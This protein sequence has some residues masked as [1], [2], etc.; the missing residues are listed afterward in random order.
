MRVFYSLLLI[1]WGL[2]PSEAQAKP[3]DYLQQCWSQQGQPLATGY[4]TFRYQETA[5]ELEHSQYPWQPTRY[6][7]HGTAWLNAGNFL[8]QDTLTQDGK[9][10]SSKSQL[11]PEELLL[12]DYGDK[13]LL[14]VTPA[15]FAGYVLTTARYS[16]VLLLQYFVQHPAAVTRSAEPGLAVYSAPVADARVRLFIRQADGLL[17][18]A[19][20]L[21]PDELF[22]DVLTTY[23]YQSYARTGKV[24]YPTT[25]GISKL[26]GRIRDDVR[27]SAAGI[28][29]GASPVLSRPEGY[30]MRAVSPSIPPIAVQTY[31][32][33]LHFLELKHTDDRVLVVEFNDFLV[34]AEAPLTSENGEAI[35]AET[36]RLAPGKPV[37]YFV[38]GHYHPH[39]LGGLRP[40]VRQ[41]ATIL[42]GPGTA[43]YVRTLAGAPRTLRPD[44]LHLRPRPLQVEEVTSSKT[45][46]D[47]RFEMQ[48][49]FI[50]ASSAHTNDYLVYYFP[51]EKLLFEDDLVWI[52]REGPP[53]KASAR[54]AGL[55][56]AVRALN[57]DVQTVVQSWPVADYGVKTIIPFSDI[58]QAMQVK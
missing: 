45:I 14:A 37:R 34:V 35:L 30:Q 10:Y 20:V 23:T 29:P 31:S 38:A 27:L 8:R 24:R 52:R 50:G 42:C 12:L 6:D 32:P 7:K 53:R 54:Q 44:S 25:I 21:Q 58:E 4:L 19:T 28:V 22:G 39:Y 55:Y 3:K 18:H 17:D 15:R 11:S 43:D 1:T 41:G 51:S 49:H 36:R 5:N 26:N 40:F 56:Q 57:L 9:T 47:G 13:E 2:L 46:T 48:I 33:H 16:P